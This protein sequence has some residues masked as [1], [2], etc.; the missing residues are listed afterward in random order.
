VIGNTHTVALVSRFGS[1]DWLCM[2]RFDAPSCFG[3][4]L[5]SEQGGYW[6]I[7]PDGD[8]VSI[9]RSYWDDTLVLET[10]F[11]TGDGR[12]SVVDLMPVHEGTDPRGR[13]TIGAHDAVLR[14]VRGISGRVPVAF[15][16]TPRFEYGSA[17]PWIHRSDGLTVATAG[18]S[19]LDLQ[20]PVAVEIDGWF[21]RATLTVEEGDEFPF[22][23]C[24]RGS[25]ETSRDEPALDRWKD[26]VDGTRS[27]WTGWAGRCT[28][29]GFRR[30]QVVRSLVT[31]KAL[32]YSPTGG[33]VAAPTTS[34]PEQPR[35]SR[36]WDYRYCWLRDATLATEVLLETGY[37]HEAAEWHD[38]LIRAGKGNVHELQA[39][40]SATGERHVPET[41]VDWLAGYE[42]SKPVRV[43][44]SAAGQF[45]LD[46]YGEAMDLFHV[47]RRAGIDPEGAWQFQRELADVLC[48]RWQEPDNGIWEFRGRRRHFV[49]SKVMAWVALDRAVRAVEESGKAGPADRWVATR[50]QI[51]SEVMDRGIS[52]TRGC[53]V[54]S[55]G[56]EEV[57][58]SLL[59]LPLV[60][61]VPADDDRMVATID[62]IESDL[63]QDGLVRRYRT[64]K[65]DDRL[66]TGEGAFFMCTYWLVACLVLLGRDDRAEEIFTGALDKANDLGLFSEQYGGGRLL[67]NFPQAISHFSMIT[68]ALALDHGAD[69][70]G[71]SRWR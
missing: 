12:V 4:L 7:A 40:Y 62:A 39:M 29:D 63:L 56:S 33:I 71:L 19:A 57:D 52:R 23:L 55:F 24:Y 44:N 42:G 2:P 32:I 69:A 20:S 50:D 49:H 60:G 14:I 28:Y 21:V 47:A 66:P 10:T 51:Y 53:F 5:D 36:N 38:W 15:A 1:I 8:V 65:V 18:P 3:A 11:V 17:E 64:G 6:S 67:G 9:E 26:L 30:D 43:G 48:E 34:L 41:Q 37:K 68:A 27:F 58:A 35:G 70:P 31:L 22:L 16:L 59:R 25:H 61:F 45:Q 54:M 13:G 46:T